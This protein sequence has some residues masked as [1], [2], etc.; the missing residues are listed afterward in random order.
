MLQFYRLFG[1]TKLSKTTFWNVQ[2]TKERDVYNSMM[3]K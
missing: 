2:L 1:Y 3:V